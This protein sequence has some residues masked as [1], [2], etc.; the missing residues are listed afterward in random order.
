MFVNRAR[1]SMSA[2]NRRQRLYKQSIFM[3]SKSFLAMPHFVSLSSDGV[4]KL[5][6]MLC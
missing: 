3:V 4:E 5:Q 1:P 2:I 6:I